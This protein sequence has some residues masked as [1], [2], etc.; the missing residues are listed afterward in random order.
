V[1][2]EGKVLIAIGIFFGIVGILYWILTYKYNRWEPAGTLML[3]GTM[4]L[5][6]VPGGYYYWWSRRMKPRPEDDPE[7]T[8]EGSTGVVAVFPSSSIWPF[9]IGLAALLVCLGLV[10]GLWTAAVGIPIAFI[11]VTGI[12]RES[13]RGG[14]V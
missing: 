5:G 1:K 12:I 10:F 6:L 9:F 13:R 4:L 8:H 11:A 2:V 3:F 14:T 7:A